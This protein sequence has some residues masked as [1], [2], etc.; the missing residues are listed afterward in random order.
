M[1][2]TRTLSFKLVIVFLIFLLVV[3]GSCGVLTYM[4]QMAIY[5]QQCETDVRNVGEYLANIMTAEGED[6]VRYQEYYLDHFNEINAPIDAGEYASYR[7]AYER[8]F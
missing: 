2:K 5:R 3:L 7:T 8:L 1:K 6:F 4:N